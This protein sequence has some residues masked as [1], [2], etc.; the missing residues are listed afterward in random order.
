M[1]II[2]TLNLTPLSK[3]LPLLPIILQVLI[4]L[5]LTEREADDRGI[6]NQSDSYRRAERA[7]RKDCQKAEPVH[8]WFHPGQLQ[9][10]AWRHQLRRYLARDLPDV[11]TG[12]GSQNRTRLAALALTIKTLCITTASLCKN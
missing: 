8:I 7:L 1:F 6:G 11:R 5:L 9:I 2:P 12:Q 3:K 10:R 4:A